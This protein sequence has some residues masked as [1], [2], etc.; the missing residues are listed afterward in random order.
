M[1]NKPTKEGSLSFVLIESPL[2]SVSTVSR[3]NP[4]LASLVKALSTSCSPVSLS[5]MAHLSPVTLITASLVEKMSLTSYEGPLF[6]KKDQKVSSR[7]PCNHCLSC[8]LGRWSC[9]LTFW[10]P[11]PQLWGSR[12]SWQKL[13]NVSK[14]L[15]VN[16]KNVPTLVSYFV[17]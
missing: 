15:F 7:C 12:H 6:L 3:G 13:Q 11:R 16:R 17:R 14:M 4:S 10:S 8:V 1:S 2:A 5:L 9:F